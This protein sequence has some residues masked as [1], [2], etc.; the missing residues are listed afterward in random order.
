MNIIC[1]LRDIQKKSVPNCPDEYS[2]IVKSRDGCNY[3]AEMTIIY[4]AG[5]SNMLVPTPIPWS[6]IAKDNNPVI[7]CGL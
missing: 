6:D 1:G 2:R 4:V 7:R 3:N 5:R